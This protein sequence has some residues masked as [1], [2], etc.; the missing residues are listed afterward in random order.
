MATVANGNEDVFQSYVSAFPELYASAG[1]LTEKTKIE[2]KENGNL[3]ESLFRLL[4]M[5]FETS[6]TVTEMPDL[7]GDEDQE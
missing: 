5:L 4:S 1:K 7:E 3:P 2:L 6:Y